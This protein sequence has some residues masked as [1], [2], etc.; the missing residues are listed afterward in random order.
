MS[1][2]KKLRVKLIKSPI[3]CLP[4]HRATLRALGL[5]RLNK[6]KEFAFSPALAG[7]VKQVDYL[8]QVEEKL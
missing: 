8:L 2:P 5:R 7:M 1:D 4:K 6:S 3:G